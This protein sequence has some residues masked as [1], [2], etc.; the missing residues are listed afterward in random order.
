MKPGRVKR[1]AKEEGTALRAWCGLMLLFVPLILVL[2]DLAPFYSSQK[3]AQTTPRVA[4]DHRDKLVVRPQ[5]KRVNNMSTSR[6]AWLGN[7]SGGL[8]SSDRC[9]PSRGLREPPCLRH[10][11]RVLTHAPISLTSSFRPGLVGPKSS[12]TPIRAWGFAST[13]SSSRG[14]GARTHSTT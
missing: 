4:F 14:S 12:T 1:S 11:V 7:E 2:G 13:R 8:A 10:S 5:C 6:F 3:T 9:E